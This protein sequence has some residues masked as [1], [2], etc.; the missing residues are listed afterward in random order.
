MSTSISRRRVMAEIR[1]FERGHRP[2]RGPFHVFRASLAGRFSLMFLALLIPVVVVGSTIYRGLTSNAADL[3]EARQLVE[4]STRS[5]ALVLTQDDVTKEI[6]LNVDRIS[7]AERKI[8]AYD[9]NRLVLRRI[10]TLSRS[11]RL[12]SI[13]AELERIEEE[14]LRPLDSLILETLIDTGQA[15][16]Q[17]IYFTR[18][19]PL[20]KRYAELAQ[21][22]TA[23]AD[24]IAQQAELELAVKNRQSV[25]QVVLAL[26][27]GVSAVG[28]IMALI[29][30]H[31]QQRMRDVVGVLEAVAHGDLTRTLPDDSS[32][33]IGRT[34]SALNRAVSEMRASLLQARDA[35][36]EVETN[37]L[38]I[39]RAT[40]TVA[41]AASAQ[42]QEVA[43]AAGSIDRVTAQVWGIAESARALRTMVDDSRS[44]VSEVAGLGEQFQRNAQL[45]GERLESTAHAVGE[46]STSA[47]HVEMST[48]SLSRASSETVARMGAMSQSMSGVDAIAA[49]S[50]RLWQSMVEKGG[51][52][53]E[54]VEETI[55][56]IE[57][58]RDQSRTAE[59]LVSE[60][61]SRAGEIGLLVDVID[62]VAEETELLA[63]NAAIISAQA[64]ESGRAFAVVSDEIRSLAERVRA[65]TQEIDQRIRSLQSESANAMTAMKRGSEDIAR[66]VA[67]SSAAGSVVQE[68][69]A[70]SRESAERLSGI[71]DAVRAQTRVSREVA[72]LMA[73]TDEA[74][75]EIRNAV[76]SQTQGNELVSEAARVMRE[77]ALATLASAEQQVAQIERIGDH[78]DGI[79]E[80]AQSVENSLTEQ[81]REAEEVAGFL[82]KVGSRCAENTRSAELAS[83]ASVGLRA[84]AQSLRQHVQRFRV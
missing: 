37:A 43:S 6:L 2:V 1:D 30:R 25:L 27:L 40:E 52:G 12:A 70:S 28:V 45:L 18:Y 44:T 36:N 35:A 9:E 5:L 31:I 4:L 53:L 73:A 68:I 33:E 47:K 77:V 63:L 29:T 78:F 59:Q 84:L 51:V 32:D 16:A 74:V 24:R 49:E 7:E 26:L 19:E 17:A 76:T 42:G 75:R 39:A 83:S 71:A 13:L 55:R 67:L 38:R 46:M 61:G 34:A 8:A 14:Q 21:R 56:G 60:V 69:T 81:S 50:T 15:E 20:R 72:E 3:L 65:Q 62:T 23:E 48:E 66:V 10:A 57:A 58:L 64:G 82:E 22:L 54:R 79:H 41:S 11:P 80:A